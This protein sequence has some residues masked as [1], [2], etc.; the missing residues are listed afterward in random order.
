[1]VLQSLEKERFQLHRLCMDLRV[2]HEIIFQQGRDG[3]MSLP[4]T[5]TLLKK[6]TFS[7]ANF[8]DLLL[9]PR[10]PGKVI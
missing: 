9:V 1:M 2:K 7:K 10:Q 5:P 3:R 6:S 4:P 8:Y